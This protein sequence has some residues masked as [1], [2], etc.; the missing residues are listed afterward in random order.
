[1]KNYVFHP[2]LDTGGVTNEQRAG[3]AMNALQTFAK[4]TGLADEN[5]ELAEDLATVVGD[6]MADVMHLAGAQHY[7][8]EHF[9]GIVMVK[10]RSH[11]EEESDPSFHEGDLP[12]E[13][14]PRVIY[15][16]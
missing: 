2:D 16:R 11:F 7:D 4:D 13:A 8:P 5:G 3:W 12:L 1:M 6:L 10:A 15:P 9:L 14:P